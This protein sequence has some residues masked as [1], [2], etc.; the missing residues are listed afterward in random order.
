MSEKTP[1]IAIL[2]IIFAIILPL[3]GLILGIV[4]LTQINKKPEKKGKGLA[5]ASIIIGGILTL[6]PLMGMIAY[7]GVLDPGTML[8]ERTTFAAP[9]PNIDMANI[10][11]NG[12]I[13]IAFRNNAEYEIT[14]EPT[15]SSYELNCQPTGT[16]S[17]TAVQNGETFIVKW[18]CPP[19]S[20]GTNIRGTLGFDYTNTNTGITRTHTGSIDGKYR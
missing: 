14:I 6:I 3:I 10:N 12:E 15:R 20:A 16:S 9:L 19:K 8:P 17:K 1:I 4:A 5:I 11:T 2:A 18:N 7:F 13:Q